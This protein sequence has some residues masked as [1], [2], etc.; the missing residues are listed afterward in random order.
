MSNLA[1]TA[2]FG[3]SVADEGETLPGPSADPSSLSSYTYAG[4]NRVGLQW[5][6]GDATAQT[7]VL[8]D[9][10][11]F[12]TIGAG[13]TTCETNVSIIEPSSTWCVYHT[14]NGQ[15]SGSVCVVA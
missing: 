10:S 7:V 14:L 4:G 11:V 6:N 5:V 13:L 9:A 12:S 15:D 2:L 8:R 1:L 3:A